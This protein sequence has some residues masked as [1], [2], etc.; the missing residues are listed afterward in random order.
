M[1]NPDHYSEV[2]AEAKRPE[3]ARYKGDSENNV[4]FYE[5]GNTP[6]FKCRAL[7]EYP[8]CFV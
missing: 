2:T 7:K 4:G 5:G 8:F 6:D 3:G 1:C